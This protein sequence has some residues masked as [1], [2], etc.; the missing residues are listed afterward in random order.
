MSV[1]TSTLNSNNNNNNNNTGSNTNVINIISPHS[2]PTMENIA[3]MR[4]VAAPAIIENE[5]VASTPSVAPALLVTALDPHIVELEK[6]LNTILEKSERLQKQVEAFATQRDNATHSMVRAKLA[7][8]YQVANNQLQK[9][10]MRSDE[11]R[12]LIQSKKSH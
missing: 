9:M 1:P 3:N 4:P 5:P 6:E 7:N 8:Q 11:I 10:H 2:T 12:S